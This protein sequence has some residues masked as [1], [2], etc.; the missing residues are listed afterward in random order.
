MGKIDHISEVI[1][2]L[3]LK[4]ISTCTYYNADFFPFSLKTVAI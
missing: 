3:F 2:F 4:F 1:L